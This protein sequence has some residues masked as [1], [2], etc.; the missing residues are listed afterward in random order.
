MKE[1][2]ANAEQ[3]EREAEIA[4]NLLGMRAANLQ[5]KD[6]GGVAYI[7][8]ISGLPITAGAKEEGIGE[9]SL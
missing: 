2:E 9:D 4:A 3:V 7:K 1:Q 6:I 5:T 8:D